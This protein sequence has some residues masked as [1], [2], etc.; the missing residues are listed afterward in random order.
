MRPQKVTI[1]DVNRLRFILLGDDVNPPV[2]YDGRGSYRHHRVGRPDLL[3]AVRI[4]RKDIAETGRRIDFPAII[5]EA[6]AKALRGVDGAA[7]AEQAQIV[8]VR[9]ARFARRRDE[10]VPSRFAGLGIEGEDM[11]LRVENINH[12]ARN[13]GRRR[14]P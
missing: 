7:G 8:P 2:Y 3:S 9:G 13:D 11:G 14:Q 5:G 12:S 4:Q 1:I 6:A 10:L